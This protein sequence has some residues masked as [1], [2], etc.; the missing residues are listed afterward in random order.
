MDKR[1]HVHRRSILTALLTSTAYGLVSPI[2][3]A[4]AQN[5]PLPSWNEGQAKQS[6]LNFVADV[7]RE[8][9]STFVPVQQRIAT[10]DNDGTL[11]CEKPIYVQLAFAIE[12][13][14]ALEPLHPEWRD[15]EP[16]KA[17]LEG[18]MKMLDEA[19]IH[20]AV[21]LITF[22]HA[23]MTTEE[24]ARI[25]TQWLATA[26][27]PRFKRA[28]TDLVYQPMLELLAYL[29]VN[30]FMTFIVSGGGV[31]F[32]R[33][34]S[35]RVYGV[36][37]EQVVGSTIKTR[38][39]M[40]DGVPILFRLPEVDFVDDGT[41]KPVGIN[42]RIGRRPI[43]AFGNSDGDLQMLQWATKGTGARRLGLIVHHDDGAR[44]YAYD[45]HA[46]M[47]LQA[48]AMNKWTAVSMK[49]DWKRIFKF[50]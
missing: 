42:A 35:D 41:G 4:L 38:F 9:S 44:E 50:E 39:Q 43:A 27:H 14:K 6:I 46:H 23:G 16:F 1:Y 8:G 40:R 28:Y 32:I 47:V 22:T 24:F 45:D 2:L 5:D 18:N 12:R 36:T 7:T 11:W 29:R 19:G 3:P 31:E 33:P 21:E 15:K 10:F 34:W 48:A 30:R 49:D 17:A 13:V 20:G 37:P 26:R 25:V